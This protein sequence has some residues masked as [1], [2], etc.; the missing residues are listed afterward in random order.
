MNK[1]D[2]ST[3]IECEFRTSSTRLGSE[4]AKSFVQIIVDVIIYSGSVAE[5]RVMTARRWDAMFFLSSAMAPAT[6]L[7][8]MCVDNV[9]SHAS[10]SIADCWTDDNHRCLGDVARP[11]STLLLER[12]DKVCGW[13]RANCT[14]SVYIF[15]VMSYKYTMWLWEI[16]IK[17]N[18]ITYK[19]SS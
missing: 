19:S 7:W 2:L 10:V 1:S 18:T 4:Q 12:W 17:Y 16:K 11:P 13:S 15:I 3:A 5:R 14:S 8:F 6:M 9:M